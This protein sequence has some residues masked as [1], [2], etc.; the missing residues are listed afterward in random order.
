MDT[1]VKEYLPEGQFHPHT[2]LTLFRVTVSHLKGAPSPSFK[3]NNRQCVRWVLT[4]GKEI[5]A[6]GNHLTR[7]IGESVRLKLV[8]SL[9]L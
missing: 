9:A 7:L 6:E 2:Y 4:E 5:M 3:I 8:L 1:L